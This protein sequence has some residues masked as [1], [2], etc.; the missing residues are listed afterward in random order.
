MFAYFFLALR[1]LLDLAEHSRR[2]AYLAAAVDMVEL[3]RRMRLMD[4]ND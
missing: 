3:E 1:K 4:G 2:D